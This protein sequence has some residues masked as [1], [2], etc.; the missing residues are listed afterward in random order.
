[1]TT[2]IQAPALRRFVRLVTNHIS[3]N[4][5]RIPMCGRISWVGVE[6]DFGHLDKCKIP[7]YDVI[8]A[9]GLKQITLDDLYG[10]LGPNDSKKS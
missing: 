3:H 6:G 2:L 1:M 7:L 9:V 4:R 10:V 8:Q 5:Q